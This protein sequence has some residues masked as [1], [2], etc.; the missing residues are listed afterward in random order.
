M[1]LKTI[2]GFVICDEKDGNSPCVDGYKSTN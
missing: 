2:P 1:V